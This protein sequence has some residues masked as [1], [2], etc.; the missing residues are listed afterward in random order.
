MK[1]E[2]PPELLGV[3]AVKRYIKQMENNNGKQKCE[4]SDD[5]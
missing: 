1:P 3:P 5:Q 2:I 4:T